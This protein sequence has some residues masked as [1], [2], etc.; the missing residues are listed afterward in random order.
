MTSERL[1]FTELERQVLRLVAKGGTN[2]G[3]G[4]RLGISPTR[5]AKTLSS[6]YRKT[7]IYHPKEPYDPWELRGRLGSWGMA[8]FSQ[9]EMWPR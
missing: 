6:L 9:E 4:R 1:E 8:Y 7:N 2:R 3:I 5:V